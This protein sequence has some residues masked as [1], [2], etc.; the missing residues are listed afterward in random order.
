MLTESLAPQ[1]QKAAQDAGLLVNAV[2]PDVV[3][4]APPL[5]IS[6]GE[7]DTFLRELPTVLD[8]AHEGDGERRAGD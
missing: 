2:A 6:D 7:V 5:V 3:R 4:L 8:A 1:V